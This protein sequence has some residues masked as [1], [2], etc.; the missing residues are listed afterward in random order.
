MDIN[1]IIEMFNNNDLDVEKYFN[2]YQT[3]FNILKKRGLMGELDPKNGVGSEHWQNEYLLWLYENNRDKFNHYVSEFLGDVIFE[4]GK[5]I[6]ELDNRG[7]LSRLFSDGRSDLSVDTIGSILSDDGNGDEF[8]R[9]W[10]TTDDVYRDVIEELNDKNTQRLYEYIVSS[11]KGKKISPNTD[12][13]EVIAEEQGHPEYV[14]VNAQTVIKIVD[15]EESMW[16]LLHDNL[17]DLQSE[18][19]NIHSNAYNSAYEEEVYEAIWDEL[20]PYFEGHGNWV[21]RPHSYKKNT[22]V[23]VFRIPI[24]NFDENV[25]DY[26]SHNKGYGNSGTL[27]YIG[28][29]I[30]MLEESINKL[31]VRIP[32]YPSSRKI[33]ENINEF[34]RDYI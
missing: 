3:F 24:R 30:G 26:L 23:Q 18:L 20:S 7:E 16:Q 14:D 12:V 4:D 8:D 17:H 15:D 28:S 33:D 5:P 31:R 11:L 10:E 32:D 9:Y 1:D 19:S 25:V 2:D 34:F 22:K 21:S 6:L 29:Y 13:L 27:E